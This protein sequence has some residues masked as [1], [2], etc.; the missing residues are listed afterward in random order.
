[1]AVNETDALQLENEQL[2]KYVEK[3][4]SQITALQTERYNDKKH[5]AIL[6]LLKG[7]G[8]QYNDPDAVAELISADMDFNAVAN[9]V[10]AKEFNSPQL[11]LRN[12]ANRKPHEVAQEASAVETKSGGTRPPNSV[13]L[14]APPQA[15][16]AGGPQRK[17]AMTLAEKAQF[18]S[19][20]GLDAF[21]DLPL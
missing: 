13:P 18:V 17:S 11:Y 19:D 4:R 2:K 7:S 5:L 16:S 12:R 1:M 20:F 8:F 14:G 3:L 6:D 10:S 21:I 9:T 15:D